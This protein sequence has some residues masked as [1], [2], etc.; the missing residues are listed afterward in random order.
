M[1]EIKQVELESMR[2]VKVEHFPR[3]SSTLNFKII[4]NVI[5]DRMYFKLNILK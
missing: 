2:N 3:I 1:F 5:K 4:L